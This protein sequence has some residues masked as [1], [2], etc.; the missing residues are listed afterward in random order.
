MANKTKNLIMKILE[1]KP[2]LEAHKI[3]IKLEGAGHGV[4]Y[5]TVSK[6]L[7]RMI[8]DGQST[9]YGEDRKVI[10]SIRI[11]HWNYYYKIKEKKETL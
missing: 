11:K 6:N 7:K 1:E 8:N 9:R 10:E 3:M 5:D 4:T 2:D